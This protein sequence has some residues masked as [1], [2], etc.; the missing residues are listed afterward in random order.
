MLLIS[1]A[2]HLIF[3][4]MGRSGIRAGLGSTGQWTARVNICL[5][6]TPLHAE[7]RGA[8]ISEGEGTPR[9]VTVQW[10]KCPEQRAQEEGHGV[11]GTGRREHRRCETGSCLLGNWAFKHTVAQW[12]ARMWY[13]IT[14][15]Q[16]CVK[17]PD[18][19]Y[20]CQN[21]VLSIFQLQQIWKGERIS[22]LLCISLISNFEHL[23]KCVLGPCMS[24]FVTCDF[25]VLLFFVELYSRHCDTFA[26]MYRK[27]C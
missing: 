8:G 17:M 15:C 18:F 14:A 7:R 27:S 16:Q 23:F 9:G 5:T 24:S 6:C 19:L 11:T 10:Q 20:R 4:P 21:W 3:T 1:T 13:Q 22:L 26:L 25:S 12:M 2:F